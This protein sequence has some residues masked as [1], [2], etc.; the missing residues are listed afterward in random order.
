M[1]KRAVKAYDR[2]AQAYERARAA[3]FASNQADRSWLWWGAWLRAAQK[4]DHERMV[5]V[6]SD[7]A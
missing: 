7:K 6:S 2:A 5:C 4:H 1:D 3:F